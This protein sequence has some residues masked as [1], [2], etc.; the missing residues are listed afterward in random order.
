MGG[1]QKLF[2]RVSHISNAHVCILSA[3]LREV[4][5][6]YSNS[7]KDCEVCRPSRQRG[8]HDGYDRKKQYF[9][10]TDIFGVE[11]VWGAAYENNR[12]HGDVSSKK[13]YMFS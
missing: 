11:K 9:K 6:S 10:M 8:V 4:Y 5:P 3:E 13:R 2:T 1:Y 7:E 12:Q